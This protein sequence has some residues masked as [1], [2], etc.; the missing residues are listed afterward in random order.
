MDNKSL[1]KLKP[2]KGSLSQAFQ[3]S[4]VLNV[5]NFKEYGCFLEIGGADGIEA[6]NTFL[7]ENEYKW[8][9]LAVEWD[10]IL[11][12]RYQ[13]VRTTKCVLADATSWPAGDYLKELDFPSRVDYLQVDIDPASQ[14]LAALSNLPLEQYR[15][16]VITFEH[17]FYVAGDGAVRDTSR[18]LLSSFGYHLLVAG[19][20]TQG[21]NFEDWWI[22][23][24]LEELKHFTSCFAENVEAASLFTG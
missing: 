24:Q 12:S 7:L 19:A 2:C 13:A 17:D 22:D 20:E 11:H 9:G 3:E 23:P 16:S 5:L 1:G 18:E 4:L 6:S 21:R 14:S 10:K 15:F 8:N